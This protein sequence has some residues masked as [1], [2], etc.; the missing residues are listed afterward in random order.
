MEMW[1]AVLPPEAP[2][3]TPSCLSPQ[4]VLATGPTTAAAAPKSQGVL[5]VSVCVLST[6][7]EDT[8][9]WTQC[10]SGAHLN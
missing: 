2:G 6:L 5:P 10:P 9:H 1:A 3:Q 7:P 8:R 4:A